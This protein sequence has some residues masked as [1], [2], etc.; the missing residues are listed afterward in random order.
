MLPVTVSIDVPQR[1]EDVYAYLD[2]LANHEAF[3]DHMLVDW[4]LSGPDRGVGAKARVH[5]KAG[6]R[7]VPVDIE[8]IEG[9]SPARNVERNVSAG[10]KRVG[11][12]TYEL[13][14]LA[15]GGTRVSFT[16]SWDRAP[17]GDR[18]LAPLVRAILRRGNQ[19]A[20]ERLAEQLDARVSSAAAA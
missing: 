8:V 16:Y 18:A 9:D 11:R 15:T 14:E 17:F 2:V 19:R 6:G 5:S 4:S 7:K 1:R 12:G 20:M 13:T 10:G 3:T